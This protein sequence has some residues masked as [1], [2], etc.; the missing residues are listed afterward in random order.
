MQSERYE[1][2]ACRFSTIWKQGRKLKI[3]SLV[4]F[5]LLLEN[6][7]H[8]HT[9]DSAL[10]KCHR[11]CSNHLE[12][13][14]CFRRR[15]RRRKIKRKCRW[16]VAIFADVASYCITIHRAIYNKQLRNGSTFLI[17]GTRLPY[18]TLRKKN[19][20]MNKVAGSF[21]PPTFTLF[22]A[23]LEKSN[24]KKKFSTL[25]VVVRLFAFNIN[26]EEYLFTYSMWT[27]VFAPSNVVTSFFLNL[28]VCCAFCY[29]LLGC[30]SQ[31]L[32]SFVRAYSELNFTCN[33]TSA[34]HQWANSYIENKMELKANV[35]D[36]QGL[37]VG[38]H[39]ANSFSGH[40]TWLM[41]L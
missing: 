14:H 22:F 24:V 4:D 27:F 36:G 1:L 29:F 17:V 35:N 6:N 12:W 21:L 3:Q 31:T 40:I 2:F 32:I 8:I 38:S 39:S 41:Y 18:Y 20:I 25:C 15:W 5:I 11:F 28:S 30:S 13:F 16:I 7:N 23:C 9:L 19:L 26:E 33:L 37:Y 10:T 34:Y